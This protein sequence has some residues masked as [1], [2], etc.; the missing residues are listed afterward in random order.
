MEARLKPAGIRRLKK[1]M[2]Q[3]GKDADLAGVRA[4]NAAAKSAVV[5]FSK[6]TRRE[7]NVKAAKL[8]K[9]TT[10]RRAT[11]NTPAKIII[12]GAHVGVIDM[13]PRKVKKGY[14]VTMYKGRKQLF[15]YAFKA[16]M[17]S[18]HTG[19]WERGNSHMPSRRGKTKHSEQ[20][21]E[22]WGPSGIG[23][24]WHRRR[25]IRTQAKKDLAKEL[26]RQMRNI[27]RRKSG[28]K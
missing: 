15:P 23:M 12:S 27:Q 3:I 2:E 4:A 16:T 5:F 20:I 9:L 21:N 22:I 17:K 13:N 25:A 1:R 11:F 14:S 8:K 28:S 6:E 7:V 10:I 18:T 24:W 26:N 19:I